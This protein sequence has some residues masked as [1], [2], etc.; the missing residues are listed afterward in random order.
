MI[1]ACSRL[2]STVLSVCLGLVSQNKAGQNNTVADNT[3]RMKVAITPEMERANMGVNPPKNRSWGYSG[4]ERCA[5]TLFEVIKVVGGIPLSVH[6][7][8]LSL[9]LHINICWAAFV[10]GYTRMRWENMKIA[11]HWNRDKSLNNS[12]KNANKLLSL[13]PVIAPGVTVGLG[14]T[15]YFL[16]KRPLITRGT[17]GQAVW[18]TSPH[19]FDPLMLLESCN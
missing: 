16:S 18:M 3:Q 17:R 11:I 5:T 14:A 4:V 2:N 19:S 13:T 12:S 15:T 9:L 7:M 8:F 1:W 10:G 6:L